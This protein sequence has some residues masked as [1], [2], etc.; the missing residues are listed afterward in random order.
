MSKGRTTCAARTRLQTPPERSYCPLDIDILSRQV[1]GAAQ[2]YPATGRARE[3]Q[4]LTSRA[5]VP[6]L[7]ILSNR[8][9]PR[10]WP[11]RVSS[12]SLAVDRA[13]FR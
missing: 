8:F 5:V 6:P 3:D 2:K 12:A 1:M 4:R 13:E 9:A 11:G 10:R 7:V